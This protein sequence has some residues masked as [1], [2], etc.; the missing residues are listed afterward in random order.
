MPFISSFWSTVF[1]RMLSSALLGML[2]RPNGRQVERYGQH[3][4]KPGVMTAN[5]KQLQRA[6]L[7]TQIWKSEAQSVM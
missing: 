5:F 1:F 4:F 3:S 2:F 7:S 6:L